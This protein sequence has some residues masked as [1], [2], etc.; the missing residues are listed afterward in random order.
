MTIPSERVRKLQEEISR[1]TSQIEESPVGVL[2]VLVFAL[3]GERYAL[4]LDKVREVT[5]TQYITPIP[6]L[7]PAVLGATGLRGEVLPVLDPCQILG[8]EQPQMSKESRLV[9]AQH[10][11][12]TVALLTEEVED[13]ATIPLAELQPPPSGGLEENPIFLEAISGERNRTT[14]LLD[15]ARLMEAVYDGG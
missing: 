12:I 13:I 5:R 1:R 7:P 2:S 14:R 6:G 10:E 4:P 8:L 11:E 15:L 3:A 9:I